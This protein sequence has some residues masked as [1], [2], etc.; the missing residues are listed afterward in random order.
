MSEPEASESVASESVA[1]PSPADGSV[2]PPAEPAPELV[3]ELDAAAAAS[4]SAPSDV[5]VQERLW[6][7][8][9][10]LDRW[11]FLA[12]GSDDEPTPFA[13][14]T[15]EGAVIFAFSTADRAH[16]AALEFGLPEDEAARMLA[17]PLPAAAAWV[18]SYAESG[19]EA[20]VFDAPGNGAMAP[21]SNL[22]A[23]AVYISQNPA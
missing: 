8:A 16:A 19:V 22:A 15:D 13:L 11:L 21:L 3:A 12:R 23:M 5:A 9:F 1:S 6:R 18:A 14:R 2:T 7:A 4:K 10:A 17:V 20:M